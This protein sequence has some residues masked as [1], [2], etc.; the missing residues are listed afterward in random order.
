MAKYYFS[1]DREAQSF[2]KNI[3]E[4]VDFD[5]MIQNIF[6]SFEVRIKSKLETSGNNYSIFNNVAYDKGAFFSHSIESGL[7]LCN[8]Y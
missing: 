5:L 3:V 1:S 6:S 2:M 7:F 4:S 8:C